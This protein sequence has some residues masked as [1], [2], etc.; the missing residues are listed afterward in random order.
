MRRS[1]FIF[2][3]LCGLAAPIFVTGQGAPRALP[4]EPVKT[5]DIVPK[6]DVIN[7]TF[8]IKNDG[9]A[10]LEIKDVKPAC[11]CTVASYDKV[12]APGEV[13]R[14]I[15]DL[16]TSNF[17]GPIAKSIAVFTNDENNPKLQL[18]IKAE[19][20]PFL[21]VEPGYARYTIVQ[22]ESTQPIRQTVW[23]QDGADINV[24]SVKSPYSHLKVSHKVA[25]G[26]D[27]MADYAGKQWV[28]EVLLDGNSPVGALRGYVE[29]ITDHPKQKEV[30]IPIS[31]FVRP[32]QHVT[33]DKIDF[34][35]LDGSA[36]PHHRVAS[37]MNFIQDGIEVT[38]I[39]TGI[40][41]LSA[42]VKKIGRKSGHRFEL[43]LTLAPGLPKGKFEGKLVLHITDEMN[44]KI[45]VPY[46]G[47]IL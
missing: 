16:D 46:S 6:G 34:G 37:F 30:R 9:D 45:E 42:E 2:L 43:L 39:D 18:V 20:K 23:A 33:P 38:Q 13:G 10:P 14:I 27:R 47:T 22:G 36:L 41:G 24:V 26:D 8:E 31:G 12:I 4:V 35:N 7:H 28:F 44:P 11:G 19:V 17:D 40:E 1:I 25:E 32:R 29:V 3:A 15:S 5:F 21:G